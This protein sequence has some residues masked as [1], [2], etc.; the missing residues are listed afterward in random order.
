MT[1]LLDAPA[2]PELVRVLDAAG[3]LLPDSP[4]AGSATP[5][6]ARE[7]YRWMVLARRLD[8]EA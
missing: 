4:F 6:L 7:L 3:H 2:N 8:Q 5:E 1:G